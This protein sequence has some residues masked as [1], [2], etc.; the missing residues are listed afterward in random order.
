MRRMVWIA[1]CM[2]LLFP[3]SRAQAGDWL[4]SEGYFSVYTEEGEA[5]FT[6]AGEVSVD[7]E[8]ISGDNQLYR[9]VSVDAQAK[10]A[11]AAWQGPEEMPNID[12]LRAAFSSIDA[13]SGTGNTGNRTVAIY[14]THTDESYVPTDG[15]SSEEKGGG[16][17]DVAEALKAAFEKQGVQVTLDTTS[18]LPHDSGAYRRSRQT[19]VNLLKSGPDALIDVHR[20]GTPD[21]DEY[22]TKVDGEDASKVRLLVGR[23]NQNS[24]ANKD[25]A[26]QIK[27]VADEQYPGLIK[28][29]F[30]GKG[31]YNQD[32]MPQAILLEMGTHTISKE[33]ALQSADK[34]A[35]VMTSVIY[36]QS[37]QGGTQN[38]GTQTQKGAASSNTGVSTGIIWLIVAVVVAVAVYALLA[39]GSG[40]GMME[41]IKRNSSEITGGLFGKK[42]DK[43]E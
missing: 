16:I 13:S 37:N 34:I 43:D 11:V 38:T 22:V 15:V 2:A 29:I 12:W 30:I 41:K 40:R 5:L 19:A 26:K 24:A 14:A 23:S 3:I 20:D 7:D 17:L 42:P 9:V 10:T 35:T 31:S 25:F 6:R 1:L 32:L 4:E 18:H 8:Y 21:P 39:T 27:A 33:R 28:D 36:G